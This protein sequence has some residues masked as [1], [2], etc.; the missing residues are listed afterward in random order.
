MC[1]ACVHTCI[2]ACVR[3]PSFLFVKFYTWL[4]VMFCLFVNALYEWN[5]IK[6]NSC[7][8][9][10]V[11]GKCISLY[12]CVSFKCISLLM[13][14]LLVVDTQQPLDFHVGVGTTLTNPHPPTH[15]HTHTHTQTT[16]THTHTRTHTQAPAHT[17]I[18]TTQ[19]LIYTS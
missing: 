6:T 14:R 15:P 16:R 4:I 2:R 18:P 5:V 9:F 12:L 1:S 3:V 11:T 10:N 13:L 17:S 8:H 19:S 7:A